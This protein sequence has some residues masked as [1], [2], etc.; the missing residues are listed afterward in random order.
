MGP[1]PGRVRDINVTAEVTLKS[2]SDLLGLENTF[3]LVFV[4]Y[5]RP[6]ES[7]CR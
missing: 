5:H 3:K 6:C 7:G 2:Y 4:Q 1:Q